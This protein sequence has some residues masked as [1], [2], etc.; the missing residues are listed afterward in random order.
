MTRHDAGFSVEDLGELRP[1]L[2]EL[3]PFFGLSAQHSGPGWQ[4]LA[5]LL[6]D[7]A[8]LSR[9]V[10][11]AE[12][13]ICTEIERESVRRRVAASTVQL[14]LVA[15]VASPMIAG[16]VLGG[17]VIELD[18]RQSFWRDVPG[19]V[20]SVAVPRLVAQ[21]PE[22]LSD[23][24]ASIDEQ[25]IDTA[26]VPLIATTR[27]V[28]QISA[29]V[30]WSNVSSAIAGATAVLVSRRPDVSGRAYEVAGAVLALPR[31]RGTGG[32]ETPNESHGPGQFRRRSCCLIY[33]APS[34]SVC[35][36]CVL[37][38]PSGAPERPP[39]RAGD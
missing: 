19:E 37:V 17:V 9:K 6:R 24:A 18:L 15:R 22:S 31:L 39:R 29:R 4:D 12:A 32:Y 38:G 11:L 8:V 2:A 16:A 7:P 10:R 23:L 27:A 14:A 33:R 35:G 26:I 5:S 25:L 20:M 36:D 34:M 28:A 13:A 3:G 1:Q 30:L 21:R